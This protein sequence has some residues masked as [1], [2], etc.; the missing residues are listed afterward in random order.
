[1]SACRNMS[2]NCSAM[3][4]KDKACFDAG[5]VPE[6]FCHLLPRAREQK[7]SLPSGSLSFPPHLPSLPFPHHFCAL[8]DVGS[9]TFPEFL[10][11]MLESWFEVY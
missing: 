4:Q 2:R 6:S 3:V 8:S 10:N 5:K 7:L 9:C 11:H 1:M